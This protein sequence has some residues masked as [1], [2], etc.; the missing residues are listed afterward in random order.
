M[1]APESVPMNC[2]SADIW[3]RVL[4]TVDRVSPARRRKATEMVKVAIQ[5]MAGNTERDEWDA[6]E[7][8]AVRTM[9]HSWA[10]EGWPLDELLE[11]LGRVC[12][13]AVAAGA[14]VPGVP[15]D[16]L[17]ALAEC[18]NR[19]MR[20]L[21]RGYQE[22]PHT[23]PR[24]RPTHRA[25]AVALLRGQVGS[26]DG[27]FAGA[28][29]VMVFRT[30]NPARTKPVPVREFGADVLSIVCEQGGYAL[31]PAEDDGAW[32]KR[33]KRIHAL[34]PEA[35][36]AGVSRQKVR[37][38]PAGRGEAMHVV[39]SALAARRPPGCYLLG[40]VLVE[41][42]VL[43][44]PSVAGLLVSKIEP[45]TRNP[46]LVATLRQL[47]AADGN[48]SRAAADLIIHRS[49]LDYR[50]RRIEQL[51]GHDPTSV[52]GLQVLG[53]AITAHEAATMP[54]PPLRLDGFGG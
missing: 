44:Q 11:L 25:D 15:P 14:G 7:I 2:L 13:E 53:A 46:A 34:L 33:C 6:R 52:R 47:L 17:R 45:V 32:L 1:S 54:L 12:E 8:A 5:L 31:V 38:V 40:D 20:E 49:T 16:R 21:L 41:Y 4:G 35:S 10:L 18:N 37:Q 48:R 28:Y 3:D 9:G 39:V 51:T 43:T 36:W 23:S 19:F 26:D 50:L 29:A 22:V 30:V 27:R 24:Q 42:A